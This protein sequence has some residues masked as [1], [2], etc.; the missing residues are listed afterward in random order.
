MFIIYRILNKLNG[1]KY[2]GMTSRPVTTRFKEH[3]RNTHRRISNAI[4]A[5][6]TNNFICSEIAHADTFSLALFLEKE[7]IIKENSL[8]PYGYNKMC[9]GRDAQFLFLKN[10][11]R[12]YDL[13]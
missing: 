7:N 11:G 3:C 2:V 12:Q 8:Q 1:K 9:C 5:Y 6:G 4:Q 10:S 13:F